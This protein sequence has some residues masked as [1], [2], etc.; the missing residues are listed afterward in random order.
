MAMSSGGGGGG[1]QA[2]PNVTPMIDVMLVLLIIFMVVT[3]QLLAGFT[4][5]PPRAI[6]LRE[7][8]EDA[9]NDHVLGLDNQGRYYFDKKLYEEKDIG[10]LIKQ[11][12]TQPGR[13]DFVIYIRADQSLKYTKVLDAMDIAMKNGVRVAGLVGEQT[14]GTTS[15]VAGDTHAAG[16]KK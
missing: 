9:E 4:A 16:G 7:H 1:V 3:P 8:P 10:P 5:E 12:Y 2:S 15:T 11:I 6:N 14:P 13:E